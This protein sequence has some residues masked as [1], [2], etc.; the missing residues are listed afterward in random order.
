MT[1][2]SMFFEDDNIILRSS[3]LWRPA[4]SWGPAARHAGQAD[5]PDV[6]SDRRAPSEIVTVLL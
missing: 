2:A 6:H 5:T 4:P 3:Q 1:G